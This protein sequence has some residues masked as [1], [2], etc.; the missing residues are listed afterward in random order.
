M[1]LVKPVI[2]Q[3]VGY[4]NSGKTTIVSGLIQRLKSEGI[5]VMTIKHHGHGGKPEVVPKKDSSAYLGSGALATMV[6]GDGRLLI[7][8]EKPE[9]TLEEQIQFASFFKPDLIIIEGYKKKS[10][11]KLLLLR[12]DSDFELLTITN[13]VQAVI[14]WK[15]LTKEQQDKLNGIPSFQIEDR[16]S[17]DWIVDYFKSQLEKKEL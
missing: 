1:A 14:A 17:I 3:V 12:S 16:H 2:F 5:Q 9:W 6:E 13:N 4:Q 8:A 10:F 11:P 15:E 7:H